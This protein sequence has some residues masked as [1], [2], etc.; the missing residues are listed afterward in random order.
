LK[1]AI[2]YGE[3]DIRL[4]CVN[5]PIPAD[6]EALVRV[7]AAGICGSDLHYYSE[8]RSGV[9]QPIKPFILG[10]EFSGFIEHFEGQ[11]FRKGENVVI[12]PAVPCFRCSYCR[13]GRYNLCQKLRFIG[14]AASIPHIDG[15]FA[16]YCRVPLEA[17]HVIPEGLAFRQ[18]ALA[19]PLSVALHAARRSCIGPGEKAMI[20]GAG[21]IGL[22]T[23]LVVILRGSVEPIV[24]DSVE[25][26][27]QAASAIG[28]YPVNFEKN[29]VLEIVKS[30]TDSQ[31][32]DVVFE[33]SGSPQALPAAIKAVRRGGRII[34]VGNLPNES[35]S[36]PLA[37]VVAKEIDIRGT[38][39]YTNTFNAAITLLWRRLIP[40]DK[41]V[42]HTFDLK[43]IREAFDTALSGNALK[44]IIAP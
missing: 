4:E 18:A 40:V 22:L 1:A 29:D 10:H 5:D 27:L 17:L 32:V 28:A 25:S 33:A 7:K 24:V 20:L 19:E 37:D 9:F 39:R 12:E 30:L 23:A 42:T 13:Q 8:G 6:D 3:K 31:G 15:G 16:E 2:F 36:A 44:V 11:A 21:P 38:L 35:I 26:R 41:I 43:D 14:T 34:L